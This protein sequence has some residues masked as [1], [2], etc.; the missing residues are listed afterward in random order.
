VRANRDLEIFAYSASHDLQ[1]P[2]RNIALYSQLLKK[3]YG[4]ELESEAA[5]FVD[6]ILDNAMHMETL[7]LDLLAYSKATKSLEGPPPIVNAAAILAGVLENLKT[8]IEH[9]GAIVTSGE[10]P[11]VR[12]EGIHLSHLFQNLIGNALKYRSKDLPRVHITAG[13]HRGKPFLFSVSDNGI[14]IDPKY[15]TQV[16]GLF[17]RLHHRNKY[18]GSGIGLAICQRIV[19]QYGGKIWVDAANG[20]GSVFRFTIPDETR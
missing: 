6:G 16:F 1:E 13:R 12:M 7:V 14:G 2:L 19:E 11:P 15:R 10:L 8:Q 17:K 4:G 20:G 3:R 18:P 5:K 9:Y